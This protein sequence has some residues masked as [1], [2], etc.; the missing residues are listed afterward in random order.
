M[1]L[2]LISCLVCASAVISRPWWKFMK[3]TYFMAVIDGVF[4]VRLACVVWYINA[5][6]HQSSRFSGV[7]LFAVIILL[8][9]ISTATACCVEDSYPYAPHAKLTRFN[10]FFAPTVAQTQGKVTRSCSGNATLLWWEIKGRS[11]LWNPQ[12][13]YRVG[14]SC[15]CCCCCSPQ[16]LS[17]LS[18]YRVWENQPPHL[19]RPIGLELSVVSS[20]QGTGTNVQ[21][22]VVRANI[23]HACSD[24]GFVRVEEPAV[25]QT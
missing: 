23:C 7:R 8:R 24:A 3:R 14:F 9:R 2:I 15:R 13:M 18:C 20:R 16:L 5:R 1:S 21:R 17:F 6:R 22:S 25:A 4:F 11:T 12:Y 10:L 19:D